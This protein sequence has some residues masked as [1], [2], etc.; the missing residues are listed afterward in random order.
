LRC[1]GNDAPWERV[2]FR[3]GL[4]FR[5]FGIA[6][7]AVLA[8]VMLVNPATNSLG[9]TESGLW[10]FAIS[11]VLAVF[12]V[13]D[14]EGNVALF[15]PNVSSEDEVRHLKPKLSS[16]RW[17]TCSIPSFTISFPL[18]DPS[19]VTIKSRSLWV[20]RDPKRCVSASFGVFRCAPYG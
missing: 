6:V 11:V 2:F 18:L 4:V 13:G 10:R 16:P 7:F 15:G 5:K 17:E 20:A 14:L 8:V 1:G 12:T 9:Y 19:P 3:A